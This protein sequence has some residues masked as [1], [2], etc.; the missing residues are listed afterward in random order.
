M[1]VEEQQEP[2]FVIT[3]YSNLTRMVYEFEKGLKVFHD[4]HIYAR[5]QALDED[6]EDDDDDEE[7]D[8]D[9]KATKLS[10]KLAKTLMDPS[11]KTKDDDEFMIDECHVKADP[12]LNLFIEH[13]T[14]P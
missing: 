11:P 1:V 13:L 4:I 5:S 2:L 8:N 10:E 7:M 6:E 12:P 14:L 3:G 9:T